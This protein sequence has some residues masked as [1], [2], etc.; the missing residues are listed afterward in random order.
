MKRLV[1]LS[2]VG[3]L[4]LGMLATGVA[5]AHQTGGQPQG[6]A[7]IRP[8]GLG[9]WTACALAQPI[10]GTSVLAKAGQGKAG[11]SLTVEVLVKHPDTSV[12]T[13]DATVTPTFPTAGLQSA[14]ILTRKGTSFVLKG[15]IPVPSTATAGDATLAV[16]GDYGA[17][18]LNCNLTVKITVPVCTSGSVS[19]YATPAMPG[20]TLWVAVMLKKLGS[21]ATLAAV[22]ATATIPPAAA[23]AA[24]T[25]APLGTWPVLAAP[26]PVPS[27][28]TL[29]AQATVAVSGTYTDSSGSTT[30][31]C[32]LSTPIK[33]VQF[34]PSG[35]GH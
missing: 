21:S 9:G 35:E 28:S 10:S 34:W 8:E 13:F 22:T 32:S 14:V 29:G 15:T 27:D 2:L 31:T 12:T 6:N 24:V 16:T 17:S 26:F 18:A 23:T 3:A 30:F 33:N 11:G 19:A 1:T 5:T 25:L 20:G 7:F 4:V